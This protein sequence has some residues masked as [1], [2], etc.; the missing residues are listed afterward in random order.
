MKSKPTSRKPAS[1]KPN[2]STPTWQP[3][4]R[5]DSTGFLPP[6]R[7]RAYPDIPDDQ[8][9]LVGG[10]SGESIPGTAHDDPL[11]PLGRKEKVIVIPLAGLKEE[12]NDGGERFLSGCPRETGGERT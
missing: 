9:G 6:D 11:D 3:A 2:L 12:E 1:R 8:P 10:P 7:R 5:P 4:V